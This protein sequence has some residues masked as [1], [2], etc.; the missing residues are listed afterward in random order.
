MLVGGPVRAVA[1]VDCCDEPGWGCLVFSPDKLSASGAE[2][3]EG[4]PDSGDV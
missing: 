4:A 2:V 3:L 1:G